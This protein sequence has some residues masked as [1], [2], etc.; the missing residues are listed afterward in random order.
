M[1][2]FA[3]PYNSLTNSTLFKNSWTD[4][5]YPKNPVKTGFTPNVKSKLNLQ[6][7]IKVRSLL[8]MMEMDAMFR[9]VKQ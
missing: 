6:F 5:S 9:V 1:T 3:N 7:L 4:L 2:L 8:K